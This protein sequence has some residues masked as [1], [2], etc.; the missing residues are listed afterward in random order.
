[1]TPITL[2]PCILSCVRQVPDIISAS[3]TPDILPG[4][5]FRIDAFTSSADN[6]GE[7]GH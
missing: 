6:I 2:H 1:M 4:I 3:L 7:L 5:S